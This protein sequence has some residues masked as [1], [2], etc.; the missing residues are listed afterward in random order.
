[1]TGRWI[2]LLAVLTL[3]ALTGVSSAA[4]P[5]PPPPLGSAPLAGPT[6]LRLVVPNVPPFL[7][8]VDTGRVTPIRGID[9]PRE[10]VA[11]TVAVGSDAVV[12]VS[13]RIY[14]VRRGATRCSPI[15]TG[16]EVAPAAGGK[17]VWVKSYRD[18]RHCVLR[19]IRLDGRVSRAARRMACSTR[20]VNAGGRAVIVQGQTVRDPLTG[21]TLLRAAGYSGIWAIA[22][23]SALGTAESYRILPLTDLR[24]GQ[25]RLLPWPS[26]TDV[27]DEAVVHPDS[28]HIAVGFGNFIPREGHSQV[29]DVWL[30]DT[31]SGEFQHL[32]DMPAEIEL[33]RSGMSWTSDGRLVWLAVSGGRLVVAV[34]R[35]GE[36]RIRVRSV[37]MPA[38]NGGSDTFVAWAR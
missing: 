24:T 15:G 8:D 1:M 7:F 14:A 10:A 34:W 27:E 6:G 30:L 26:A 36:D 5:A 28:R 31:A 3:A 11:W 16:R 37:H 19:R 25:R 12:T 33:K 9:V 13:A 4:A 35:P 22:G 32:P 18:A 38:R 21:R 17:A 29:T 2:A 20:L 23:S